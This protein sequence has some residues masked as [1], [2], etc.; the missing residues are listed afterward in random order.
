MRA[1]HP[2]KRLGA[3]RRRTYVLVIAEARIDETLQMDGEF[4]RQLAESEI[5][6]VP[7]VLVALV[8][9]F[10]WARRRTANGS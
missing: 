5:R 1:V 6:A 9:F 7:S 10:L 3:P 4:V 2:V 8:S